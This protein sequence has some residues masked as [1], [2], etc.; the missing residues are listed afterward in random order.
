MEAGYFEKVEELCERYSIKG[1]FDSK[2]ML[3]E[4]STYVDLSTTKR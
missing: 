4:T 3:Q 1:F 2:G